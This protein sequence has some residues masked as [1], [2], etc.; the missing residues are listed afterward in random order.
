MSRLGAGKMPNPY[1]PQEMLTKSGT[2]ILPVSMG[3][4]QIR[5]PRNYSSLSSLSLYP[6]CPL[7]FHHSDTTGI[8][9]TGGQ[10]AQPLLPTKDFN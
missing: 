3:L 7:R 10:D 5:W 4:S 1:S 6:L 2:G 8:D 9:I